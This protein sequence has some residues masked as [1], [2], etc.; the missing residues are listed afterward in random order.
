[1]KYE[2]TVIALN[3]KLTSVALEWSMT[4]LSY[5]NRLFFHVC[6]GVLVSFKVAVSFS[7]GLK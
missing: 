3:S 2:T 1:M 4:S 7:D 5:I 6:F